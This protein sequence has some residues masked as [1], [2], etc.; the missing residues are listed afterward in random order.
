V[1]GWI[2]LDVIVLPIKRGVN[3]ADRSCI[4][5]IFSQAQRI[6]FKISKTGFTGLGGLL[7]SL[8]PEERVKVASRIAEERPGKITGIAYYNYDRSQSVKLT[9]SKIMIPF[10]LSSGK[11]KIIL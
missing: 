7:F 9:I 3:I 6:L 10:C 2:I 1:S 11:T 5:T 4:K 8:F